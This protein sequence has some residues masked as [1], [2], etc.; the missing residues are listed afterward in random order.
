MDHFCYLYF[1]FVMLSCMFIAA[2]LLPLGTL[3][4]DVLLYLC[5]FPVECPRSGVVLDCIDF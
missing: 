1:V 3:V 5:N 4:C 2:L